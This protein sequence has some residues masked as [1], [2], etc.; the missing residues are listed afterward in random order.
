[1]PFRCLTGVAAGDAMKASRR[2]T[3]RPMREAARTVSEAG[4]SSRMS[5]ACAEWQDWA[6]HH[7]E[8]ATN[9]DIV[10]MLDALLAAQGSAR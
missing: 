5:S 6:S 1:M 7:P 9:P 2:P 3:S 10:V 8:A 4:L